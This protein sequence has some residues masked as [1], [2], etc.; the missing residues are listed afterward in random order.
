MWVLIF[1]NP[2]KRSTHYSGY[3]DWVHSTGCLPFLSSK[4]CCPINSDK[5]DTILTDLSR[6]RVKGS[7][8]NYI[9]RTLIIF[10]VVILEAT[11]WVYYRCIEG[12]RIAPKLSARRTDDKKPL[13]KIR[14]K[15]ENNIKFRQNVISFVIWLC[16]F[17]LY[18]HK[19]HFLWRYSR[20]YLFLITQVLHPYNK[21]G[22]A[23][24]L[25]ILTTISVHKKEIKNFT[26]RSKKI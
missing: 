6:M 14:L 19:F 26:F 7:G 10:K 9:V 3:Q 16:V 4:E 12:N 24:I 17:C 23:K 15:M 11:K 21:V 22:N 1:I 5:S 20:F 2:D 8:E 13:Y 25:R 18:P